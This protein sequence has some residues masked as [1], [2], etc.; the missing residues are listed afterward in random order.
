MDNKK[1]SKFFRFYKKDNNTSTARGDKYFNLKSEDDF[2]SIFIGERIKR[3]I[4]IYQK[5][6]TSKTLGISYYCP[7]NTYTTGKHYT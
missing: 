1:K 6:E 7:M 4:C 3:L 5:N 2:N